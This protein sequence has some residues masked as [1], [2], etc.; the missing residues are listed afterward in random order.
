MAL[1]VQELTDRIEHAFSDEWALRKTIDLP[2]AGAEDRRLL[3]AAVARG[4]LMYLK[5]KEREMVTTLTTRSL[6]GET[7][8]MAIDSTMLN[9]DIQ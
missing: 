8:T 4:V 5:E 1:T 9:I 7:V 2:A 6:G 3:F